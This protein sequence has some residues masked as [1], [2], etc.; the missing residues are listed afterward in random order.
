[1]GWGRSI[2]GETSKGAVA[3]PKRLRAT[4]LSE[5]PALHH[6]AISFV[7]HYSSNINK[8]TNL[9]VT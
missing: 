8:L 3:A 6:L 1:M 9:S 5:N 7:Y 4:G 2:N